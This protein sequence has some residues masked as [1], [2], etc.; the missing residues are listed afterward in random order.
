MNGYTLLAPIYQFLSKLV[1]GNLLLK[2]QLHFLKQ[3]ELKSTNHFNNILIIGGGNGE[4]LAEVLSEFPSCTIC[5]VESSAKMNSLA[6]KR[7]PLADKNRVEFFEID[8]FHWKNEQ[9]FDAVLLPFFLD[10]FD[11]EKQHSLLR[12]VHHWLA[13]SG[14]LI[15]TDFN[16]S[17]HRFQKLLIGFMYFVF[18]ALNAAETKKLPDFNSLLNST[19][20]K[21]K[22]EVF[23]GKVFYKNLVV[24]LLI[25]PTR[26]RK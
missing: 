12:R 15:V 16:N 24:S 10:L 1:F 3:E 17:E 9:H 23:F 2:A 11:L 13:P 22:R 5:Y 20:W 6:K 19:D 14:K 26:E 8:V 4:L 25:E 18:N 7:I 21:V